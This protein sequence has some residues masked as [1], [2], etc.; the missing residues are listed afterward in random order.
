MVTTTV[1]Q[2]T[3]N[4]GPE[5]DQIKD[6]QRVS[7]VVP[8]IVATHTAEVDAIALPGALVG[9]YVDAQF[10]AFTNASPP[11]AIVVPDGLALV[12]ARIKVADQ[13]SL[14]FLATIGFAGGTFQCFVERSAVGQQD[15]V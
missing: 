5:V 1:T 11:V 2:R 4:Y 6:I 7:A 10:A 3:G 13:V 15:T 12:G 8:A 14:T 9:D